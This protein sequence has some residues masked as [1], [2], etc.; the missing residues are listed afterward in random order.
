MI[1]TEEKTIRGAKRLYAVEALPSILYDLDL[2]P[3]MICY[4]PARSERGR[5]AKK[6]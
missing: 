1:D 3:R 6:N 5:H 4:G 2:S